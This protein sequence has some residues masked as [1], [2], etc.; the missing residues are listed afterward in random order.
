MLLR[1]LWGLVWLLLPMFL[2]AHQEP[3]SQAIEAGLEWLSHAYDDGVVTGPDDSALFWQ[4]TGEA[5]TAFSLD[6]GQALPDLSLI[7]SRF[8][9]LDLNSAEYFSR[10]I[11]L[12]LRLG[13]AGDSA[14]LDQLLSRQN[15]DGGFGDRPGYTSTVYDTAFALHAMAMTGMRTTP[16][17]AR[18]VAFLRDSQHADGSFGIDRFNNSTPYL[19]ALAVRALAAY[20]YVY[21]ISETLE[22]GRN[23]LLSLS[24]TGSDWP[25][26]WE[27][28]QFLLAV[29]PGTTNSS[30]YQ[31]SLNW[32]KAQQLA[33]G[34]WQNDVFATALAIQALHLS[35]NIRFP[36][37]PD[38]ATLRGRLVDA[39]SG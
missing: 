14:V 31:G 29:V 22:R 21:N 17:S 32:L 37:E 18:A 4:S 25:T 28:A 30:L 35:E 27:A 39:D 26:D 10:A 2:Y 33:N 34:S 15:P 20:Q 19:S 12:A 1:S 24:E 3:A 6:N 8:L 9:S 7:V 11:I 38:T 5:A 23:Y 16:E 36:S 13:E